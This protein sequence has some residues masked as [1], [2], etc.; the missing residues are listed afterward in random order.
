MAKKEK[1]TS[2]DEGKGIAKTVK[3]KRQM[4]S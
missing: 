3:V 2:E 1:I 4:R